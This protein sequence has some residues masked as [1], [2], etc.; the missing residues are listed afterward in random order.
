MRCVKNDR[1]GPQLR[2][3]ET[4]HREMCRCPP[5][6]VH[7]ESHKSDNSAHGP[8]VRVHSHPQPPEPRS[9]PPKRPVLPPP[10][11]GLQVR[12][13][14]DV[15]GLCECAAVAGRPLQTRAACPSP[16]SPRSRWITVVP[17][18]SRRSRRPRASTT[19]RG[20]RM[21]PTGRRPWV[22]AA[23]RAGMPRPP[24]QRTYTRGSGFRA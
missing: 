12:R 17:P 22:V 8:Y 1:S 4:R 7:R 10:C 6:L 15:V 16:P 11:P 21:R 19:K 18:R 14:P 9:C 2:T 3:T 13:D 5:P 20:P 24:T 23:R